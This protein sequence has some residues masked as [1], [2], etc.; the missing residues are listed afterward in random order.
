MRKLKLLLAACALFVSA[1]MQ[2]QKDVTSQYITNATLAN[3]TTG[4]TNVN[5]NAPQQGNT[6]YP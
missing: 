5:F 6:E 4:W 1:G 3:G 2:A